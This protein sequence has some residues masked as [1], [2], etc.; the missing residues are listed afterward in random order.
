M[1]SRINEVHF[2]DLKEYNDSEFLIIMGL[3]VSE[4]TI[5]NAKE[6]LGKVYL[7]K[8]LYKNGHIE[9]LIHISGNVLGDKGRSDFLMKLSAGTEISPAGRLLFGRDVKWVSDFICNSIDD[10]EKESPK[11]K[12]EN[13]ITR[14]K[15]EIRGLEGYLSTGKP[16][17]NNYTQVLNDL[18]GKRIKLLMLEVELAKISVV[19]SAELTKEQEVEFKETCKT[20]CDKMAQENNTRWASFSLFLGEEF[21]EGKIDFSLHINED[22]TFYI[23]PEGKDGKTFDGDIK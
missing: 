1:K 21:S 5:E 14:T 17:N 23:H 11:Q 3:V 4:D 6:V 16:H 20:D 18:S 8:G 12:I 19:K 15:A 22:R 13:N 7:E 10:Y 2:G 9:D